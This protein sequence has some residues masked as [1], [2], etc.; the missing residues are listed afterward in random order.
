MNDFSCPCCDTLKEE[1]AFIH[2][3]FSVAF[4]ALNEIQTLICKSSEDQTPIVYQLCEEAKK[5][6]KLNSN[7]KN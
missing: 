6:I 4:K 5:Q 7:A 2:Q 3:Q 1:C